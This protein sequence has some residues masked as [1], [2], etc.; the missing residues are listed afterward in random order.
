MEPVA[1]II[2]HCFVV[3]DTRHHQLRASMSA[4]WRGSAGQVR[5]NC[6]IRQQFRIFFLGRIP[7]LARARQGFYAGQVARP[8]GSDAGQECDAR[9]HKWHLCFRSASELET[10]TNHFLVAARVEFE[11]GMSHFF[12]VARVQFRVEFPSILG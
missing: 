1:E 10:G 9:K 11:T 6:R 3:G 12:G 4:G 2:G 7:T 8:G 5:R